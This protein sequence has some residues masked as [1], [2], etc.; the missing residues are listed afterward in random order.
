MDVHLLDDVSRFEERASGLLLRDEARHNLALGILGTLRDHPWRYPE[1]RFW[2][3]E[4]GGEALCAALR[5]PPHGIVLVEPRAAGAIEAL[6]AGIDE[7]LPGAVGAS[8][9]IGEFADA[10][11]KRR[12]GTW[13]T[14][15]SQRIFELDRLIPP[16]PCP[17]AARVATAADREILVDWLRAFAIE[18]L[19]EESPD[20]TALEANVELKLVADDAAYV[21][22][23]VDGEP[24]SCAGYGSST[25]NGS[26]IG[27]VYTPPEHRGRG[28]ASAVTAHASADRLAAGCRFCFLYTNL[29]NPTSNK[30]YADLGYRPVCDSL[31]V[32]FGSE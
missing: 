27:P 11:S 9:E 5:T 29:A 13:R 7:E 21:L 26:R 14:V 6:A 17:G 28:Y 25:P 31:Q 1:R 10:W 18:A 22:W 23:E 24:V 15:F 2:V 8:P 12:G 3:V 20:E 4:E 19:G 30:I 32:A 16:R